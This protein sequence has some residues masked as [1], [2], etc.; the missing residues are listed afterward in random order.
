MPSDNIDPR[1]D[2]GITRNRA[3]VIGVSAI[4]IVVLLQAVNSFGCYEHDFTGYLKSL[5]FISVPM[6]PALVALFTRNPLRA[7]GASALFAPWLV[8][9]YY[10]DCIRPYTGGGASM[11]YIVVVMYGLATA[12]LGALVSGYVLRLFGIT[13][14]SEA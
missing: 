6:L 3:Q 2:R 13:V 1:V 9:A 7:C 5:A 14:R 11:I 12:L 4:G 8:L 10:T